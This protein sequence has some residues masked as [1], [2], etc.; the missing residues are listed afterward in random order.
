MEVDLAAGEGGL[1]VRGRGHAQGVDIHRAGERRVA[2]AA[3]EISHRRSRQAVQERQGGRSVARREGAGEGGVLD[4]ERGGIGQEAV[5]AR[6]QHPDR[7]EAA[8]VEQ[9]GPVGDEELLALQV[10]AAEFVGV[11]ADGESGLADASDARGRQDHLT[12]GARALEVDAGALRDGDGADFL[13]V[14]AG[15]GRDEGERRAVQEQGR[16]VA[17]LVLLLGGREVG[18]VET[19]RERGVG[20][21][22]V[23]IDAQAGTRIQVDDVDLGAGVVRE[24][25]RAARGQAAVHMEGGGREVAVE[26][27]EVLG[28]A[29]L[30]VAED[31]GRARPGLVAVETHAP[32]AVAEG[33]AVLEL[34]DAD[35]QGS[36][37]GQ[38]AGGGDV[39]GRGVGT[40]EPVDP[41]GAGAE[42]RR[43]IESG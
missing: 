37:P 2:E 35:L 4:A 28:A 16:R 19:A 43:G 10:D 36:G 12:A 8:G 21:V 23:V 42:G 40:E 18:G 1:V 7:Q 33:E 24:P 13:A 9:G 26:F 11:L 32:D 3:R 14:H 29:G 15:V 20:D 17:P 22:V 6:I 25:A 27:Q 5:A 34:G 38:R 39:K 31:R 41:V 30:A